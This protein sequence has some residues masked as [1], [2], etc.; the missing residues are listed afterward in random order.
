MA[1]MLIRSEALLG[2]VTGIFVAAG[3]SEPE[4]ATIS[5]HLVD[6][7]LAGH[8]SH[9]VVRVAGYVEALA[10][11]RVFAGKSIEIVTETDVLAVV[12]GCF[13]FGQ[14]VG[15]QA[16]ALGIAKARAA[17]MAAVGLR[18]AGHLGRISDWAEAGARAG[19]V[20][21]HFVNVAGSRLVAP[22]GSKERRFGTNP[23]AIGIPQRGD[24]PLLIDFATSVVAEGKTRVALNGGAVVP[25]DALIGPDGRPTGDPGVLYGAVEAGALPNAMAGPGALRAMGDH[26]GSALSLACELLA[27]VLT[28]SGTAAADRS[29]NGMLSL[30]L[31]P[32]HF[33]AVDFGDE[34]QSFVDHVRAATPATPDGSVV[35]PGDLERERRAHQLVQGIDLVTGTWE[36]LRATAERLGVVV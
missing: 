29:C 8:P 16:V 1:V 20:S 7:D 28:G 10:C 11:Q 14:T 18:H 13:G 15:G 26:K 27:G 6:S 24:E 30:Y 21:L 2:L 22:F 31:W 5:R 17:G 12:D 36:Q 32:E 34:V 4:A 33:A 35:V 23:I 25:D 19:L 9:G 3:C